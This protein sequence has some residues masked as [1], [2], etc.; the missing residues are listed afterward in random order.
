MLR[1]RVRVLLPLLCFLIAVPAVFAQTGMTMMTRDDQLAAVAPA[2]SGQTGL[3][4]TVTADTLHRGDIS[5]GVYY[6][7]YDLE[8]APA[9]LSLRPLS[10]RSYR[11]MQYDLYRL[12]VSVG[13]GLS[14]R[15]E[16]SAMAPWAFSASS[17][18]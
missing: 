5:F 3:F 18:G 10:A 14:D 8:A 6:Q 12:S 9:P 2:S 4:E 1:L 17:P 7:D 16:V 15:W 11:D 13:Y